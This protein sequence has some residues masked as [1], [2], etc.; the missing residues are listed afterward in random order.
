MFNVAPD[1]AFNVQCFAAK[2]VHSI[3]D[4][5]DCG[6][7]VRRVLHGPKKFKPVTYKEVKSWSVKS[8]GVWFGPK[9][10]K[11]AEKEKFSKF[12]IFNAVNDI[13]R[14][15]VNEK[16]GMYLPYSFGCFLVRFEMGLECGCL[17]NVMAEAETLG[18]VFQ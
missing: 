14:V 12:T 8:C 15:C 1:R 10:P 4:H 16:N 17:G 5:Y 2:Y 3:A 6:R 13:L 7:S 11:K 18:R 9:D